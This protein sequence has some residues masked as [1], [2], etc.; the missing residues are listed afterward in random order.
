MWQ[1]RWSL[2][3]ANDYLLYYFEASK[4]VGF[5]L[6]LDRVICGAIFCHEKIW[7]NNNELY[8]DEGVIHFE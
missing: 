7:W 3:K 2:D 8:I 6:V 1:C 4:F 5:V